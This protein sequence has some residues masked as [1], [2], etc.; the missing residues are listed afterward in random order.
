MLEDEFCDIVRKTRYGVGRS[1]ED[2]ARAAGLEAARLKALESGT[3]APEA[4]EVAALAA[5]LGLRPPQL[6][7]IALDRYSPRVGP[8]GVTAVHVPQGNSFAYALRAGGRS[9]IIDAGG[10]A[11]ELLQATNGSADAVFL[12]HGHSDH[13][14]ALSAVRGRAEVYAHPELAGKI[15]GA[16]PLSDGQTVCGLT[17]LYAPGHSSD[18]LTIVGDGIAFVGDTL[19]AGSLG[20]AAIPAAYPQLISSA[21]RILQLPEETLL[22]C[23]HGPVTSVGLERVHNAYNLA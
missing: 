19:F 18:M 13:V 10:S 21:R 9:I 11:E 2:V 14:A 20:R 16:K 23:G 15:P 5:V 12:T 17:A 1:A 4:S 22:F 6:L 7:D 8:S 3:A